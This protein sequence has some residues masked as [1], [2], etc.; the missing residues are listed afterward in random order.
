MPLPSQPK[1]VLQ[2]LEGWKAELA[3]G[4]WLVTYRNKY[5]NNVT[6]Q[7]GVF[8]LRNYFQDKNF[9]WYYQ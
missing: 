8:F 7:G 4:S 9:P 6:E 1:L 3:L 5:R 2:T